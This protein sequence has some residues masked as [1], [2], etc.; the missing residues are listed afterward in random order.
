M[1][2]NIDSKI[3]IQN[4]GGLKPLFVISHLY[5][6]KIAE[7]TDWRKTSAERIRIYTEYK[8]R[9]STKRIIT[10]PAYNDVVRAREE[11]RK[12]E[13]AFCYI[14]FI[15]NVISVAARDVHQHSYH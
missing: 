2:N 4:N 6:H 15:V 13:R 12:G 10:K 14:L 11:D 5:A 7:C 8:L 3:T 1:V 9:A